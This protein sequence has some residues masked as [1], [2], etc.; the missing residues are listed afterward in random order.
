MNTSIEQFN[1]LDYADQM[2]VFRPREPRLPR[3]SPRI[4]NSDAWTCPHRGI[5]MSIVLMTKGIVE[6][7]QAHQSGYPVTPLAQNKARSVGF[8]CAIQGLSLLL[9]GFTGRILPSQIKNIL[10]ITLINT[11]YGDIDP[12]ILPNSLP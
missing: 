10:R 11:G 9:N 6:Y 4:K 12:T 8:F 5:E 3:E 7:A 2:M 1:F